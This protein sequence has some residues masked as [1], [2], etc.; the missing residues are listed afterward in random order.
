MPSRNDERRQN[1]HVLEC[2]CPECLLYQEA[3]RAAFLSNG[4]PMVPLTRAD[5]DRAFEDE[6]LRW[7]QFCEQCG[8]RL[9]NPDLKL[10][11][12]CDGLAPA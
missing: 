9:Y 6:R 8:Y 11:S 2:D 1:G 5:I 10:C 4:A 3:V 12:T 7:A